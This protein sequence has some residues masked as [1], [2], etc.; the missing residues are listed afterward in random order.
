MSDNPLPRETREAL[1]KPFPRRREWDGLA[2]VIAA[3]VGLL[4]LC[5][6]GYTAWLQREQVRAQVWPYLE[7]GISGSK[8]ELMLVNKGVGPALIRSVQVYVD[9]KPQHDWDGVYAALGLKF[10]HRPPYSTVSSV[11]LSAGEHIDQV[12]FRDADDFNLY[13]RQATR[14]AMRL[15]YCST[16]KECW[17]RDEREEDSSRVTREAET[18]PAKGPDDFI[19][20]ESAEAAILPKE[21]P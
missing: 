19:D 4:A 6:S 1:A 2:A 8:R 7:T 17:V 18:C 13:A 14:V 16:M 3:L 9:G 15:C 12:S 5:V 20:N 11:V 10:E 21:N